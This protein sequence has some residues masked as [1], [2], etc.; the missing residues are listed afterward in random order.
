MPKIRNPY[1][2][3]M[4]TVSSAVPH[5]G[6]SGAKRI[7]IVRELRKLRVIGKETQDRGTSYNVGDGDVLMS[8]EN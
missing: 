8:L 3:M 7:H 1:T 5:A 6:R 2:G 4:Q